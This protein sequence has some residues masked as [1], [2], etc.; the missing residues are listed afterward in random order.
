M[1]QAFDLRAELISISPGN[2]ELIQRGRKLG[3]CTQFCGSGGAIIGTFDG[4]PERFKQLRA[5]YAEMGA[6]VFLPRIDPV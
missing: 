5:S 3:A 6:E 4:D 2:L 1:N